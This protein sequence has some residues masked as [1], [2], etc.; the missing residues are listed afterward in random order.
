MGTPDIQPGD[1]LAIRTAGWQAWWIRFGSALRDKP[2]LSN[3]VAVAHHRDAKGTVWVIEGRPGG[4]G[5]RDATHY[6]ASPGL[7]TNAGQ[8]KTPAQRLAVTTQMEALIGT[9]YDWDAI[10]ADAAADLGWRFPGWDPTWKGTVPAHVV[11]SSLAAYAYAKAGLSHPAGD[12]GVQPSAW[13]EFI[14]SRAWE[15]RGA[16]L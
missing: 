11:C 10:I 1:V 7:L 3:H 14:I 6:L 8:V 15:M 4:A 13:D 5:W 12:R 9:G 16:Q 2:N